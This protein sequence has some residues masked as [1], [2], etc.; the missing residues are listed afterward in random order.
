WQ[1]AFYNIAKVLSG[2]AFVYLAGQLEQSLGVVHAWMVVMGLFGSILVA[3]SIYHI[4]V[5]PTGGASTQ[6]TSVR[7]GFE[8]LWDVIKTFFEKKN[9]WWGI[10]FIILYRFAEGQAIKIAPLFF[11]AARAHGGLGLTTSQIGLVYGVFGAVAFVTGSLLAGY[12][13][14]KLEL[15]R[16]LFTLCCFFNVPFVVYAFLAITQPQSLYIIGGAVVCEYFGY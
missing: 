10:A 8:T 2:G 14:A 3:L 11:K 16:A 15:K 5:L 6:V 13:V 1:N 9:I 12:Y 7:K 4:R